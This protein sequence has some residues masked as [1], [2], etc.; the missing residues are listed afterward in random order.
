VA[1]SPRRAALDNL[2]LIADVVLGVPQLNLI[3][4]PPN[5]F[6]ILRRPGPH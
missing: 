2:S 1:K 3:D 5:L 4:E 6:L